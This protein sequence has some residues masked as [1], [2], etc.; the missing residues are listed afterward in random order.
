LNLR[1]KQKV[2]EDKAIIE[3]QL[4]ALEKKAMDQVQ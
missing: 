2:A 4:I 3:Q 1:Y